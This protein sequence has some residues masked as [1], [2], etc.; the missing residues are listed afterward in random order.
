MVESFGGLQP[1]L[2]QSEKA[3]RREDSSKQLQVTS[4]VYI[5]NEASNLD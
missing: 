2:F 1:Y 5:K 4:L 3:N